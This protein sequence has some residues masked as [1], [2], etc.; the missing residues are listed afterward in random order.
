MSHLPTSY[1][2]VMSSVCCPILSA[3]R[4]DA[5]S[6]RNVL[7]GAYLTTLS[8]PRVSCVKSL[9]EAAKG[10]LYKCGFLRLATFDFSFLFGFFF[11]GQGR[12]QF[13]SA[14][15]QLRCEVSGT[16]APNL[17]STTVI[18][19]GFSRIARFCG[20]PRIDATSSLH[21]SSILHPKVPQGSTAAKPCITR[22]LRRFGDCLTVFWAVT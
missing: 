19:N 9:S 22:Y 3:P 15:L 6:A 17:P 10:G 11:C 8:L 12:F 14:I 20:T 18:Y 21:M 4:L 13:S 1:S 5:I 2:T 7:L 16:G